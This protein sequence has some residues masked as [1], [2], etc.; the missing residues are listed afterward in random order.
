MRILF[1]ALLFWIAAADAVPDNSVIF[2]TGTNDI[3]DFKYEYRFDRLGMGI[4]PGLVSYWQY[5]ITDWHVNG[6]N[7]YRP[8]V[9]VSYAWPMLSGLEIKPELQIGYAYYREESILGS[10]AITPRPLSA[11]TDGLILGPRLNFEKRFSSVCL[12]M[13]QGLGASF[14]NRRVT[15]DSIGSTREFHFKIP[16]IYGIYAG[17]SW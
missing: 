16:V 14:S 1:L 15:Y 5:A 8:A 17:I 7:A 2:T 10:A 4:S 13:Y 6:R 11:R 9:F 12:G 3:S